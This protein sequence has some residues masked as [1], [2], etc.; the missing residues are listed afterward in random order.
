MKQTVL[1][2]IATLLLLSGC[3][4]SSKRPDK[5]KTPDHIINHEEMVAI[6]VDYH[7]AESTLKYYTRFGPETR[8]LSDKIYDT[9]MDKH[10]IS[11]KQFRNSMDFYSA[12]PERMRIVYADVMEKLSSIQ[13]QV[14]ANE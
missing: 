12:K 2:I 7:L 5:V 11:R 13:S 6:L 14:R 10:Q 3:S 8:Q 1:Y 4:P 9:V